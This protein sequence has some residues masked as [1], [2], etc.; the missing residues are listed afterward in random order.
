MSTGSSFICSSF[1]SGKNRS[2]ISSFNALQVRM[3]SSDISVN[4]LVASLVRD[5]GNRLSLIAIWLTSGI[6]W[7][8]QIPTKFIRCWFTSSPAAP[9]NIPLRLRNCIIQLVIVNF[10]PG[11][12]TGNL[13]LH[14][15]Q[16]HLLHTSCEMDVE[17][18]PFGLLE[19]VRRNYIIPFS[20]NSP[21]WD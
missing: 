18:Y 6:S 11:G 1:D 19:D 2:K 9:L 12:N 10:T 15:N 20:I 4:L 21:R 7:Y 3:V 8:L 13:Q 16:H 14:P 17:L 5:N